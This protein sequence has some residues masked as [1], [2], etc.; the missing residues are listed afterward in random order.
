MKRLVRGLQSFGA[1]LVLF[2]GVTDAAR[3]VDLSQ[4]VILVASDRL[5]GSIYEQTVI[6]GHRCRKAAILASSS[7]ARPT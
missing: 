2:V 5:A 4:A 7:I 3:A 1:V 6:V